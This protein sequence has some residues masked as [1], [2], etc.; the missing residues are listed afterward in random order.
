MENDKIIKKLQEEMYS[1]IGDINYGD[2]TDLNS[3]WESLSDL[4]LQLEIANWNKPEPD[5]TFSEILDTLPEKDEKLIS[6]IEEMEELSQSRG[7][8]DPI[9][10]EDV[11]KLQD[12]A[13]EFETFFEQL[14]KKINE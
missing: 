12:D 14:L 5:R 1:L 8:G 6:L 10:E 4:M 7:Y 2:I 9:D 3:H 13:M 11:D